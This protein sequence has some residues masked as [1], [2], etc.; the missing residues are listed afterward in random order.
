MIL[1]SPDWHEIASEM[2]NNGLVGIGGLSSDFCVG[3]PSAA[4]GDDAYILLFF[5]TFRYS[6]DAM[7][8]LLLHLRVKLTE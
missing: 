1:P 4:P 8:T 3:E 6:A 2:S 5:P 7:P